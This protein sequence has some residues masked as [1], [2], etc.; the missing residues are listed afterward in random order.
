[1]TEVARLLLDGI[2]EDAV[3]FRPNYDGQSEEPVVLPGAFPNLLANGS[4]G[5]AV[6]MATS[7][8]PHN[9]AELCDAALHPDRQSERAAAKTLLKYVPGPDFPTGGVIVDPRERDRR[10]LCD[11]PRLVPRARAL[12][13]GGHRPR[14]LSDRRHRN[15]LA[16]AEGAAGRAASPSCSTRRSCRWSPTCATSRPRTSASSSSRESRTVDPDAA[17]GI[18]V[19]ADRARE[20]HSAQHERAGE[21]PRPEG[22]SASPR[23]CANGSTTAARCWCGAPSYRLEQIEHRLEVLGGYLVAYLNLDKVIKII[24]NEDEPKPVL[25][26]T[27]KLTDVQADAIL[28]MR[29]RNLRK[30]E[31]MEITQ[32]GQ[33]AARRDAR[34]S[35][36]CSAPRRSSGRR[37]PARSRRCA[38]KFGPKTPLGKRRTDVRRGARARRGGD[39][40]GDGRARADHRRGLGEGLDPR[41]A[42]PRRPTCRASRSR[43]TTR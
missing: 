14:H 2:D 43:P 40:G 32:G 39:R 5:I 7:I 27:F 21:G 1:M 33:G 18:A 29:L 19:Q 26:K 9:A 37:S 23:R 36:S 6:G 16:G 15:S 41:A 25:M 12:A 13:Q 42:R 22:R 8:P 31:E 10:S 4:Q 17:D 35:K 3:D 30:L 34:S 28:N 20:P 38:T 24:R 11:R